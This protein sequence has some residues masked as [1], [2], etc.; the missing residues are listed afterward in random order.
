MH[1][2]LVATKAHSR[3]WYIHSITS[4]SRPERQGDIRQ[5]FT[6]NIQ[7]SGLNA[8]LSLVGDAAVL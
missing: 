1:R 3:L 6:Q 2:F 7:E 5:K 4:P 8:F